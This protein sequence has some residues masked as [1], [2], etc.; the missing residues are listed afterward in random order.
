MSPE[1][2]SIVEFQPFVTT[3]S[4]Q[5][6]LEGGKLWNWSHRITGGHRCKGTYL[7]SESTWDLV[8]A[9]LYFILL[10]QHITISYSLHSLIPFLQLQP[11][12]RYRRVISRPSLYLFVIFYALLLLSVPQLCLDRWSH[13][14]QYISI[15][16]GQN[17][18]TLEFNLA[19]GSY[20]FD[21]LFPLLYKT[22]GSSLSL[23]G[24]L[25][26]VP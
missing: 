19:P 10:S 20:L 16:W 13:V 5:D 17:I 4:W 15:R 9:W 3:R 8:S 25:S 12:S 23:I 7:M 6:T 11:A 18:P 14:P 24:L 22:L 2:I 21:K 1:L 26:I